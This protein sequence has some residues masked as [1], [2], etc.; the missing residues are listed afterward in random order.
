MFYFIFLFLSL[1]FT[2]AFDKTLESVLHDHA[3]KILIHHR[4]H[5]GVVYDARLP[6]SLSEIKVS[7]VSLR[8]RTLWRAGANFSDFIV[9]PNTL[10]VPYSKRVLIVYHNLGNWSSFYYT[11][12]GYRLVSPVIGFLVYDASLLSRKRPSQ[13]LKLSKLE[14]D[15]KGKVITIQFKNWTFSREAGNRDKRCAAFDERGNVTIS[16]MSMA[17]ECQTRSQGHFTVVVP[18]IKKQKQA[19]PFW[20]VGL[21]GG[22]VGL[23]LVGLAGNL[24]VRSLAGKRSEEIM[25]KEADNGELL[26][27]YWIHSSKMPRAEVT[28]TQPVL[29]SASLPNP[30]LSWFDWSNRNRSRKQ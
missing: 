3:L 22:F 29:E 23:I 11:L 20:I 30:I 19:W 15:T 9:P 8:S 4:P 17:S 25:E 21:L 10:P 7:V 1:N 18:E 13:M 14:L 6:S 24:A 2:H 27:T 16:E 28:R 26:Q 5:T 12:S